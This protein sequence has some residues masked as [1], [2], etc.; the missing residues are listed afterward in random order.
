VPL[1]RRSTVARCWGVSLAAG[2]I[3]RPCA[4]AD[5]RSFFTLYC[6]YEVTDGARTRDL[7]SRATIL[8]SATYKGGPS[9][10]FDAGDGER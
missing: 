6:K 4:S 7:G 3:E 2:R 1:G 10:N 8:H 9:G 5:P